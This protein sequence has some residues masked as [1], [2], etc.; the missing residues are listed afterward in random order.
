MRSLSPTDGG[1]R[2]ELVRGSIP[3]Y[4]NS[5][6]EVTL[7]LFSFSNRLGYTV[8]DR[9]TNCINVRF[10]RSYHLTLSEWQSGPAG[11]TVP[12]WPTMRAGIPAAPFLSHT[13]HE[14]VRGSNA[15]YPSSG[16]EVTLILFSFPNRWGYAVV[17]RGTCRMNV[18]FQRPFH[19]TL[20]G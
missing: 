5:G 6:S 15:D 16:S 7:S 3:D 4:P 13:R 14:L 8:V 1:V 11:P 19:L 20:S 9:G 17:D 18:W 12:V 2:Y 10:Q